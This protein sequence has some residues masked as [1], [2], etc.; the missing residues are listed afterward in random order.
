LPRSKSY[1][2]TIQIRRISVI[3]AKRPP[4]SEAKRRE[5]KTNEGIGK[6][7]IP[8]EAFLAVLKIDA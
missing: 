5:K 6:A 4:R 7:A 3:P 2:I 1:S 8:Q